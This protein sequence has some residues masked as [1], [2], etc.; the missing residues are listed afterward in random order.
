[1]I[2]IENDIFTTVATA[3][4]AKYPGIYVA[5]ENIEVP[6]SFPAVTVVESDNHILQKMRTLK[7]EN[8]VEVMYTV[9][10]FSDKVNG[11]K[12]E[13]KAIADVVD[14]TLEKAGFTRTLREQIPNAYDASIFRMVMRYEAIIGAGATAGTYLVYQSGT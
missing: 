4:R 3:L 1:M 10:V 14:S 13:A 5:G 7:I 2:D 8:A 12:A 11:K 9:N 6:P